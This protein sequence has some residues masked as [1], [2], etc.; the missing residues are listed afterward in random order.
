MQ[1]AIRESMNKTESATQE[2]GNHLEAFFYKVPKKNHDAVVTNL[3]KF[4]PWF[5]ENG[6]KI[7]Y[8]QY[9]GS[10]TSME[11]FENIDKTLSASEDEEIWVELQYYRDRKHCEDI[12]AKMMKDKSLESLGKEF[13]GL[14]SQGKTLVTGGFSRLR[15]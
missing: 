9:A 6:V 3:K 7:E 12:F 10:Q 4:V 1:Y 8:Y 11:G 5:D 15:E 2:I 14:I 13:F